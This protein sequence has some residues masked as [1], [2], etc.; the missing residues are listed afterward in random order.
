M[1]KAAV[2]VRITGGAPYRS[3]ASPEGRQNPA[4]TEATKLRGSLIML[5]VFSRPM[6]PIARIS[7]LRLRQDGAASCLR[8]AQPQPSRAP[9]SARDGPT[10]AVAC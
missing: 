2:G 4:R 3:G 5:V 10:N 6:V 9:A 1:S 7:L 8:A